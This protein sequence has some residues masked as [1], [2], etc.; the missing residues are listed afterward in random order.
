TVSWTTDEP[1]TSVVIYGEISPPTQE[2]ILEALVTTHIVVIPDL[3]DCTTYR[4]MVGSSDEATNLTWDDNSGNN[5]SGTTLELFVMLEANMDTDPGWSYEGQWAWGVPQGNSGDPGSGYTSDNVVGY[6]LAGSYPN[7]LSN[8]Y[9]TTTSF[10]C[11]E[12]PQVY[13]SFY[14]WLGI[15]S[16]SYDH[17]SI[18]I[19]NN[20]GNSW[21]TIWNHSGGSITS[22]DWEYE[23]YDLTTQLAGH[24]DCL[25]RWNMGPTDS[26]VTYCGWNIDDVTIMFTAPCEEECI[27]NG[28]VNDDGVITAGDAQVTFQIALGSYSPTVQEFCSADCNADETVTAGDAQAVFLAA[29]GSG[30]CVDPL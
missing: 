21:T 30:A 28:D 4:F 22:S 25:I 26:S 23:E 2:I 15:E 6:N 27:N 9:C 20:G 10:D 16:S 12:A 3:I 13:F 1:S 19:S 18:A 11:S 14:K 8:T 7:N 29:L 5:Y 24:N 17:A